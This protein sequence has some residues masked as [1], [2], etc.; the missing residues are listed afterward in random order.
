ALWTR[1]RTAC[2][3]FFERKDLQ[4]QGNLERK[5]ELCALAETLRDSTEWKQTGARIKEAQERWKT[6]G[7]VPKDQA[8]AVWARFHGACEK[9]FQ[10]RKAHLEK[11]DEERPRNQA[12]K[13]ELCALVESLDV[14]P[15]DAERFERIKEAQA[16]WKEIG[17]APREVEDALWERFRKP[18]DA[19]FEG[20]KSR[21][22]GERKT[23]EE[24]AKAKED[25]CLEAESLKDSTEWKPTIEKI[26]ALQERW[27][28]TGPAPREVDQALWRRF[29]A[30]CDVFFDRLKENAARR[31]QER[32]SNLRRKTDLCFLAEM[33]SERPLTPEEQKARDDWKADKHPQD[34]VRFL[35][36]EGPVDWKD[37]TEKIKALQREW[38]AIGPVP[39]DVSESLWE[40]FHT[41]C[42]AFFEE[43]RDALGLPPEDPQVNLDKKLELIEE[44][45]ALA[46]AGPNEGA[47]ER[48]RALGREWRRIGSVPRAQSDYVWRRFTAAIDAVLGDSSVREGH[49]E[50]GSGNETEAE[51]PA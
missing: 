50:G 45:E 32:G 1:F 43:R 49:G 25:I 44:A 22:E 21:M 30:A 46:Q 36:N 41:A 13:E 20:R 14:L 27:K 37:R 28:A 47:A 19:Y 51:T 11:L 35:A 24:N 17:P 7:P 8:E 3:T 31:D 34:F 5:L 23:R 40:R 2:N 16:A 42:D 18:I 15:T 38:K 33:L 10:A 29:R 6:I 48:A 9:F 4:Q 39:K 12:K 26:K